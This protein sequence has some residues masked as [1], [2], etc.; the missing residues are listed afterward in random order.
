MA[1]QF[2]YYI[3]KR[4]EN[5]CPYKNL[6]IKAHTAFP[7][8]RMPLSTN[9]RIIRWDGDGDGREVQKG[10]DIRIPMSDSC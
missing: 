9:E 2:Y 3:S 8:S 10:R 4:N 1:Q 7:K 6:Q 5:M